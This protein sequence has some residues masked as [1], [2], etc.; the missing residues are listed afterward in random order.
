MTTMSLS[1]TN[2][3]R[4]TNLITVSYYGDSNYVG[5]TNTLNQIVTN[6]PPVAVDA[7]YYRAKGLSLK[8]ALTNLLTNVYGCGWRY[9]HIGQHRCRSDQCHHHDR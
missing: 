7:T 5:S 9:E 2:L 4:G 3:P 1:I 8:I 6:H